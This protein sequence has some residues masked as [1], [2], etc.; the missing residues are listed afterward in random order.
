[1]PPPRCTGA[2]KMDARMHS[3][4]VIILPKALLISHSRMSDSR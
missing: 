1:M 2:V 3:N 4:D